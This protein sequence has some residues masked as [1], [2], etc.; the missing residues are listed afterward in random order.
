M[1]NHVCNYVLFFGNK[2]NEVLN[3]TTFVLIIT[4]YF[5]IIKVSVSAKIMIQWPKEDCTKVKLE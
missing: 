4:R 1:F 2:T 3:F 5:Y